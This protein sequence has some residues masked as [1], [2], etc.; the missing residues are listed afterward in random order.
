MEQFIALLVKLH[1]N[2]PVE[3]LP[4][5][6]QKRNIKELIHYMYIHDMID[7]EIH[8]KCIG[9]IVPFEEVIEVSEPWAMREYMPNRKIAFELLILAH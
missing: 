9:H 3:D 6:A 1:N 2:A 4:I 8:D 5:Y 7:R